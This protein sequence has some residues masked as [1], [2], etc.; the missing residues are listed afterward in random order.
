MSAQEIDHCQ[1]QFDEILV[2]PSRNSPSKPV[3]PPRLSFDKKSIYAGNNANWKLNF[4]DLNAV[5]QSSIERQVYDDD[6]RVSRGGSGSRGRGRGGHTSETL[7]LSLSGRKISFKCTTRKGGTAKAAH[8][9]ESF[10]DG[11]KAA[12]RRVKMKNDGKDPYAFDNDHVK[13][14]GT[15]GRIRSLVGKER[16]HARSYASSS[17]RAMQVTPAQQPLYLSPHKKRHSTSG[18]FQSPVR[19]RPIGDSGGSGGSASG[20]TGNG[21]V[22]NVVQEPSSPAVRRLKLPP[23][24]PRNATPTKLRSLSASG[25]KKLR[26]ISNQLNGISGGHIQ[27]RKKVVED[28]DDV[29]F[30]MDFGVGDEFDSLE[31]GKRRKKQEGQMQSQEEEGEKE[32]SSLEGESDVP[33][34]RRLRKAALGEVNSEEAN[35]SEVE[36]DD[37]ASVEAHLSSCKKKLRMSIGDDDD[38][39]E[40]EKEKVNENGSEKEVSKA[41]VVSTA[42]SPQ[43][44]V[45]E[46]SDEPKSTAETALA[47]SPTKKTIAK[48]KGSIASFFTA[49]PTSKSAN[50]P[51]K[52]T[53]SKRSSSPTPDTYGAALSTPSKKIRTE[54]KT[55]KTPQK[56]SSPATPMR[57]RTNC[58][59]PTPVPKLSQRKSAS[60]YFNDTNNGSSKRSDRSGSPQT[61]KYSSEEDTLVDYQD[62]NTTGFYYNE[63]DAIKDYDEEDDYAKTTHERSSLNGRRGVYGRNASMLGHCRLAR[64]RL[65]SSLATR[66][67]DVRQE[68]RT[69]NANQLDFSGFKAASGTMENTAKRGL[70]F[71]MSS[72]STADSALGSK[73]GKLRALIPAV[74]AN[75]EQSITKP[76]TPSIPGI[77]NLGNTCYLSASLQTIFSIPQFIANLYKTYAKFES[78][79]KKM[80]LTQA[81]LEVAIAIGVLAQEDALLISGEVARSKVVSGSSLATANPV[82]L[83][84]VMDVLTDKFAGYEQRDAHEFLS[85]LV[86]FLHDEL[87]APP[88]AAAG[89]STAEETVTSTDENKNPNEAKQTKV[90]EEKD[91]SKNDE[92]AAVQHDGGVLLP[93]DEYFHLNVRVCLECDSCGYSRSKDEMYRHL[94]V[95][96]GEDSDLEKWT[97]ERSLKQFFQPEKREIK[98][99]KCDSGKTATQTMEI[100]SLPKALLLHFKRF[101]V[102][103]EMKGSPIARD[104][105]KG[106]ENQAGPPP[107]ME[108]VLR[109]NKAKIPLDE[110]LSIN[111]FVGKNK[112]S[113]SGK[114]HL[115]GVVHHVGNT[116]FSGHYTTCA[117]RTLKEC[118]GKSADITSNNAPGN[119]EQW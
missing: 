84:R 74:D 20:G 30:A 88:S 33:K 59:K 13:V 117:K 102:T 1:Y 15:K 34:R 61:L 48:K 16:N 97:V 60:R 68:R 12:H 6:R 40:E 91:A 70:N 24:S 43:T 54:S 114:Y 113:P 14:G 85:D 2:S 109:K 73:N 57:Q 18:A 35:D 28:D 52:S 36:F 38:M 98:C 89:A 76:S 56:S 49:K 90:G 25:E 71:A 119:E 115:R 51:A 64:A 39:D 83:K 17:S 110:S 72:T 27:L 86:D 44:D 3:H 105:S 9:L 77:Q 22:G 53:S 93:T 92:A 66:T 101:I 67:H 46:A 96:V 111:S 42:S 23:K 62:D 75:K 106:K 47:P 104:N 11:L 41:E 81:L 21:T 112:E 5:E 4:K 82:G 55:S 79:M 78:P 63:D 10:I 37:H 50:A 87:A 108:M 31:D 19:R 7:V 69:P 94:S 65:A 45:N 80:P 118:D 58:S 107:R 26:S 99:E 103:Q 100:I 29:K 8:H 32:G 116:A 95:D